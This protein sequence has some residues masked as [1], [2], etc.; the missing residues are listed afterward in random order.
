MTKDE[1]QTLEE[2]LHVGRLVEFMR[3]KAVLSLQAQHAA[4]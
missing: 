2:Y 4:A 3:A 1:R